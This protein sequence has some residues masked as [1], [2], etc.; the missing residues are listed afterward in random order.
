MKPTMQIAPYSQNAPWAPTARFKIGKV[1]V[2]AVQPIHNDNT[3]TDIAA[4]RMRFG[5]ISEMTTDVMGANDMA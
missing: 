5:K 2:N 4:P 3:A 1:N